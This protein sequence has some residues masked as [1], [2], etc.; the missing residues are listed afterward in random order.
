M[1]AQPVSGLLEVRV[2]RKGKKSER[3]AQVQIRFA[4]VTLKAPRRNPDLAPVKLG[5]IYLNEPSPPKDEEPLSWMLLTTFEVDCL[6]K[7]IQY[8]QYYAIRFSIELFHKVLKSGCKI[9]KRQLQSSEGLRRCLSLDSIVAWRIMFLT[10]LGR[11][12]P[13]LPCTVIFEEY[14]WKALYCFVHK[15]DQPP[16]TPP[17]L[18]EAV[19]LVTIGRLP[20]QKE[21]RTSWCSGALAWYAKTNRYQ[22]S[23]E[24]FWP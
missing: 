20:V 13:D 19:Q 9:E 7:A 15:T 23:L 5:A 16:H 6:D 11:T 4:P 14:E 12:V 18:G 10:M 8:A 22:C 2:P 17:S 3:T 24:S 21:R 1:E